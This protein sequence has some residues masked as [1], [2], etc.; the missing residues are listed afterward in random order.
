MRKIN[1]FLGSIKDDVNCNDQRNETDQR[2][3]RIHSGTSLV[4]LGVSD[5]K[6]FCRAHGI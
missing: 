6:L 4:V 3:F 5:D 2:A 1:D